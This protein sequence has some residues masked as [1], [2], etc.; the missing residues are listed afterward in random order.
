L[1]CFSFSGI[2]GQVIS[3]NTD[4]ISRVY[5]TEFACLK[6]QSLSF[7]WRFPLALQVI[8]LLFILVASP[9]YPES[10]RHLMKTGRV[11]DARRILLQARIDADETKV[12]HEMREIIAAIRFEASEAPPSYWSMLTTNDK[13]HT[14]RRILL[15]AGVQIMQ[16]FTGIDFIATYAPMM[17]SLAG[18]PGDKP[19]ILAGGNFVSYTFSLALAIYLCDHVGRRRLMLTGCALMF[20]VLIVGG[21]LSHEVISSAN[22]PAQRSRYGA[23]VTA[24]LYM[25]TF[26][27]G[28]TW[29]TTW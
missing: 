12:E 25:Y 22:G 3:I 13:L 5:W 14:R 20:L 23:G 18:Y 9:F 6:T 2:E 11:D 10:P 26:I 27:Y 8:F 28:S 21:I 15:G 1:S 19:A 24:V 16:K 29:L 4:I 7:S 17:F